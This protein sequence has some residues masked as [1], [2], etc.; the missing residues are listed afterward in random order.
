MAVFADERAGECPSLLRRLA[1]AKPNFG[2]VPSQSTESL[3]ELIGRS[4]AW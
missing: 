3:N 1:I 2:H 4:Q